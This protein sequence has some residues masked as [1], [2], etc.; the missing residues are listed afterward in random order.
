MP[1]Q[2]EDPSEHAQAARAWCD[3]TG[4]DEQTTREHMLATAAVEAQLAIASAIC[5]LADAI[6]E[7]GETP[8]G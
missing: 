3:R 6:A 4:F 5:R 8:L 7:S 2:M 1:G